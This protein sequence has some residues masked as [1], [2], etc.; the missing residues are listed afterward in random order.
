M[1]NK[2]GV[3]PEPIDLS[4]LTDREVI[5]A[6]AGWA[7]AERRATAGLLRH[8]GELDARRLYLGAGCTSTFAYCTE[9]LRMSEPAAYHRI[10][11]ARAGRRFPELLVSL[12]AGDLHLSAICLL[13]PGLT[14]ENAAGWIARVS[15]QSKRAIERML[16]GEA[17][18][19][20]D[21]SGGSS[22]SSDA[23][24]AAAAPH[25]SQADQARAELESVVLPGRPGL[26]RAGLSDQA[27][28][29]PVAASVGSP[30]AEDVPQRSATPVIARDRGSVP[31]SLP[32]LSFTA[33]SE[34]QDLLRRA[35]ELVSHGNPSGD[36]ATLLRLALRSLIANTERR[37]FGQG[38][39][40]LGNEKAP[41]RAAGQSTEEAA[42]Q[43]VELRAVDSVG[44]A[45]ASAPPT[46]A[47]ERANSVAHWR[48]SR[49]RSRYI[50]VAV[51]RAVWERDRGRCAF[52]SRDGRRCATRAF[53][54]FHH[55]VEFARGGE[56]TVENLALRCGPHN[57]YESRSMF[58]LAEPFAGEEVR[59]GI[60]RCGAERAAVS[61]G[62]G[63]PVR[64]PLPSPTERSNCPRGQLGPG[65]APEEALI[66]AY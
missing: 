15:G 47:A 50:P 10:T 40:G 26:I 65:T 41:P 13:A 55:R 29:A 32:K 6:V 23:A 34:L 5:R 3:V 12:A 30:A 22:D 21:G 18:E 42:A 44:S 61:T 33:D 4:T 45:R 19:R 1:S 14:A 52:V 59:S 36:L 62:D 64:A 17:R 54:Q 58:A 35:R 60:G 9:V 7:Q 51:R 28:R 25:A 43:S 56:H 27:R 38:G 49:W 48:A 53:L 66:P 46:P 37:R 57:R 2:P 31:L 63:G 24:F 16:A 11:A 39:G 20:G 8:L